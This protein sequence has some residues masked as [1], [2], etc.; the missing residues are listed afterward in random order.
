MKNS[1]NLNGYIAAIV[2]VLIW[3][4][5]FISTKVL[6]TDFKP[7]E[8]LFFRF[9]IA[10]IML[11]IICPHRMKIKD[12]KQ[13]VYFILA[14]LS[15]ITLYYLLENIAL[16]YTLASNVGVI[17]SASPFFTAFFSCILKKNMKSMTKEFIIG[18]IIAFAG[19]FLISFNDIN[20]MQINP[21]G[22]ILALLAAAVWAVYS[23]LCRKI[24]SFGYN[25]ILTTR[26]IFFYGILFMIPAL[27]IFGFEVKAE[28]FFKLTN[29]YNILFLGFLA[30]A[31]C[32]VTW[33]YAVKKL[34][35]IKTS[36]YIYIVPVITIVTSV[37]VLKE[38][39]TLRLIIGTI[40]TLSGLIISEGRVKFRKEVK[41]NG[42]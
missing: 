14:G 42:F 19:I 7:I 12:K 8:I 40:L 30:S 41:S 21:K 3:G 23:I 39:I 37:I 4:T 10:I 31:L 9:V 35:A 36:V 6:L 32:F 28:R 38:S 1:E 22:D 29:I 24:G 20:G 13:E 25:T 16:T 26:R 2:T 17:V 33:N 34:G 18:F 15:G 27:F 11:Y 5:T